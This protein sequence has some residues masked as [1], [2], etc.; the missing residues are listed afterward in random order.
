VRYRPQPVDLV[1]AS[2]DAGL[3][4]CDGVEMLLHQAMLSFRRWTGD[5]PPY[6]AARLALDEALGE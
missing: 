5:E 4:S 3:Q 1:A 2:R 6:L